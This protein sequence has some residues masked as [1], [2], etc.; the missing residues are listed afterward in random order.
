M[1]KNNEELLNKNYK[2]FKKK[3]AYLL[4]DKNKKNKFALIYNE[5]I[6]GIYE[7]LEKSIEVATKE[8]KLQWETFLIQKIEEQ[9][10]HY[11]SR[12]A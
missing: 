4:K 10:V 3:L 5:E 6:I 2:F 7:T 9:K 8:K 12:T 1:K 11:I